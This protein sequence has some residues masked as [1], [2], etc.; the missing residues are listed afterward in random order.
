MIVSCRRVD[1]YLVKEIIIIKDL[2]VQVFQTCVS[3]QQL[4]CP[5]REKREEE[6]GG[7]VRTR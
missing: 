2:L 7:G 6:E 5:L 1:I 3:F 4:L